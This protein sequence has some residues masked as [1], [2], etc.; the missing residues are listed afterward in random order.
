MNPISDVSCDVGE[1]YV[2]SSDMSGLVTVYNLAGGSESLRKDLNIS[3]KSMSLHPLYGCRDDRPVVVCGGDRVLL[4]TK[5]RFLSHRKVSPLLQGQGKV[6]T[7]RWCAPDIIAWAGE[8]GIAV[9]SFSGGCVLKLVDR[10][11]GCLY[12]E[13]YNC[14]LIWEGPNTIICGWGNWVQVL[15]INDH[16]P[17]RQG[18]KSGVTPDTHKVIVQPPTYTNTV[19]DPFRVC[20]MA[21]FGGDRYVILAATVEQEGCVQELAMRIVERATFAEIYRARISL[22]YKHTLQFHLAHTR[23]IGGTAPLVS[24]GGITSSSRPNSLPRGVMYFV[25]CV[26]TVVKALPK[27]DDDHVDYLLSVN[28]VSEAYE[29]AQ[30]NTLSRHS[31]K[32]IGRMYLKDLFT[33]GMFE[34]TASRLQS[35]IG[36]NYAEWEAWIVRFD[37]QKLSYLLV[38]VVPATVTQ[39]STGDNHSAEEETYS[40]IG[41]EYYELLL[42]RCMEFTPQDFKQAARRLAGFY[43]LEVVCRGAAVRYND[44]RLRTHSGEASQDVLRDVADAY[45]LLLK[46]SGRYEEA[47]LVLLRVSQSNELFE[48]IHEKC[49]FEKAVELL[50]DL[51][52]RSETETIELLLSQGVSSGVGTIQDSRIGL[53]IDG[54]EGEPNS[55]PS[56]LIP[57]STVVERLEKAHRGYLWLYVKALRAAN[58]VTYKEVLAAHVYL[59]A[60]LFVENEPSAM[61]SFLRENCAISSKLKEIYALC[62]KNQM[63]D[64]MVFLLSRMGKEEEGLH[65]IVHEMKN[66]R[67]AVHYISD[68]P[69]KEEQQA[70]YERLVCMALELSSSFPTING[71][72]CFQHKLEMG[73]T[74]TSIAAKYGVDEAELRASNP[75]WAEDGDVFSEHEAVGCPDGKSSCMCMIPLDLIKDLLEAV[76]DPVVSESVRL[77][78]ALVIEM[79]PDGE[80]M[81]LVGNCLATVARTKANDMALMDAVVRV[82]SSDLVS[83]YGSYHIQSRMGICVE[84]STA[85]CPLCRRRTVDDSVIFGCSHVYHMGCIT[86]Y[87][88]REALLPWNMRDDAT[89]PMNREVELLKQGRSRPR[90]LLCSSSCEV[91]KAV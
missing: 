62:K 80:P 27:D 32:D 16:S 8:A 87:F 24:K 55:L 14:S 29:H 72:K 38:N 85:V 18:L 76:V 39:Y 46:A 21:P 33:R 86:S 61:L 44:C 31:L 37:Q 19:R 25:V 56:F 69:N 30:N 82:A 84:P 11:P 50:P 13:L 88:P 6:L 64:E 58:K 20:G 15:T 35:I 5:T 70:L 45:G 26:D 34:E 51:F 3:I 73:D 17:K 41:E 22:N 53:E 81:P 63:Y 48:L 12:L 28:R 54:V 4:I 77:D 91:L 52:A 2:G 65:I 43:R 1:A 79:I 71:R 10:P 68:I 7:V 60:T 47:L 40:R 66:M 83:Y 89:Q 74:L 90:C 67:K 49:L 23:G 9:Y 59:V 78:P 57:P 42:L 36:Y 75:Q